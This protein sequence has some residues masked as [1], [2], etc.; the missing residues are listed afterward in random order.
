M[1]ARSIGDRLEFDQKNRIHTRDTT[2]N[3]IKDEVILMVFNRK[4]YMKAYWS[5][6]EHKAKQKVYMKVYHSTPEYKAKQKAYQSTPEQKAKKK[7]YMKAYQSTPEYKAKRNVP[8]A[9]KKIHK[10]EKHTRA[11]IKPL[12]AEYRELLDTKKR[13]RRQILRLEVIAELLG[14][15]T[16]ELRTP[17]ENQEHIR[18]ME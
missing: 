6:P 18:L 17:E 14:R 2:R 4:K 12:V 3:C 15:E 7:V 1:Y 9:V 16:E 8:D 11:A 10:E 13:T 5:T